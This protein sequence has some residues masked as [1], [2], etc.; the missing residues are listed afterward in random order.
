LSSSNSRAV[1]NP[2]LNVI[3]SASVKYPYGL[4]FTVSDASNDSKPKIS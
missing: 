4:L 3:P 1:L 2:P